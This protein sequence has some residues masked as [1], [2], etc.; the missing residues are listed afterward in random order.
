[1]IG[2]TDWL[3]TCILAPFRPLNEF[4]FKIVASENNTEIDII[5]DDI[6]FV[7]SLNRSEK[8]QEVQNTGSAVFVNA[9]K[10]IMAVMFPVSSKAKGDEN[11]DSS[12][13]QCQHIERYLNYYTF[14]VPA[15]FE[16]FVRIVIQQEYVAVLRLTLMEIHPTDPL[17]VTGPDG[18][19]YVI[20]YH[21]VN[22]ASD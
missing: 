18:T 17:S 14:F 16:I 13:I 3:K 8:F 12:M 15:I 9:T 6:T 20:I 10:P 1:M 19:V 21:N 7:I 4:A 2:V 22:M 5:R 11:G